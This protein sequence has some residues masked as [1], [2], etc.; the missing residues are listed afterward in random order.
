MRPFWVMWNGSRVN[1][2]RGVKEG[3]DMFL[4]LKT[5]K[6][7]NVNRLS[8]YG[9]GGQSVIWKLIPTLGK[10]CKIQYKSY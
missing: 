8:F 5:E 3:H 4:Y 10:V 1:V 9:N 6:T 7:F 2:G